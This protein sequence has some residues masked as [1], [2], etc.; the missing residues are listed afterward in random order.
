M[1]RRPKEQGEDLELDSL[2][3]AMTNVVGVLILVL[4]MVQLNVQETVKHII[5]TSIVTQQDLDDAKERLSRLTQSKLELNQQFDSFNIASERE[6]L[7]RLRDTVNARKK[8]LEDAKKEANQFSMKIESDKK[9]AELSKKEVEL[10][11]AERG[12]LQAS[13]TDALVK[14]AELEA[15]L[16]KT[17]VKAAPPPKILSI[18]NPRPAPTGAKRLNMLC[19]GDKLYPMSIDDFRKD[20]ENRSKQIITRNKLNLDPQ[21]GIDPEKFGKYFLKMPS[22]DDDFF[23]AEYFINN[24]RW[25]RL[26]MIP[27]ENKGYTSEAIMNNR[28]PIRRLLA[29]INPQQFYVVFYVLPDSYDVYLTAR[30]VLMQA[31]VQAGWEAQ[32]QEWIYETS[33]PVIELGPPLPKPPQPTTPRPPAKPANVL[34]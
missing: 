10:N 17:P 9:K 18:P 16:D 4:L 22:Y 5:L 11:E 14:K 31:G 23:T 7:A 25:P 21:A 29:G 20:A 32:T 19:S 8:L 2:M 15:R 27:R 28:S 34:D 12:K 13:I 33:V 6:R 3:D 24:N 1:K 30:Q 26:K